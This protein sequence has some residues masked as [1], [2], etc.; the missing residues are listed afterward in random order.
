MYIVQM[1][2]EMGER[3]REG[4]GHHD[5]LLGLPAS[6]FGEQQYPTTRSR[7]SHRGGAGVAPLM[8]LSD[9]DMWRGV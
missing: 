1:G 4:S 7:T 3:E 2:W 6:S 8:L 9:V 5:V